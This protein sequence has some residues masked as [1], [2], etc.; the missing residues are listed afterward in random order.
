MTAGISAMIWS[1]FIDSD[2]RVSSWEGQQAIHRSF[3]LAR[4]AV[5]QG[6]S[7]SIGVIFYYL[8]LC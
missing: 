7:I 3:P 1:I 6:S 2:G 4:T 8:F 5:S